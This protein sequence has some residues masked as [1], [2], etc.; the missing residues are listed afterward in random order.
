LPGFE[1][2]LIEFWEFGFWRKFQRRGTHVNTP[3]L[4]SRGGD[5]CLGGILR[6]YAELRRE[7]FRG[8]LNW[9]FFEVVG[10]DPRGDGEEG[11]HYVCFLVHL[12]EFLCRIGLV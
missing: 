11:G 9:C 6:F 3:E 7:L 10:G 12:G 1:R 4:G 5:F 2:D 8:N